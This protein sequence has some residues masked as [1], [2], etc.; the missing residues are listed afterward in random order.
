MD[1]SGKRK[2]TFLSRKSTNARTVISKQKRT[3]FRSERAAK[4]LRCYRDHAA[5]YNE[6]VTHVLKVTEGS[7][8]PSGVQPIRNKTI[9]KNYQG[10]STS[11]SSAKETEEKDFEACGVVGRR[12]MTGQL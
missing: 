12:V 6:T 9:P 1:S 2:S 10:Y 11:S 7:F 3:H 5:K 8:G 4:D